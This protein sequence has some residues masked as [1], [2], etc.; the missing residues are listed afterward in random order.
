MYS[1]F[2]SL[3]LLFAVT[4]GGFTSAPPF[5]S[6]KI[7]HG[8]SSKVAREDG[9]IPGNVAVRRASNGNIVIIVDRSSNSAKTSPDGIPDIVFRFAPLTEDLSRHGDISFNLKQ[10]QV[11]LQPGR[12]A[13]FTKNNR[14]AVSLSVEEIEKTDA[15]FPMFNDQSRDLPNAVRLHQGIGLVRQAPIISE[16]SKS[17]NAGKTPKAAGLPAL[18][19]V[20]TDFVIRRDARA[21]DD[22]GFEIE[23]CTAGGQ[24][25]TSCSINCPS[26]NGCAVTCG[27]GYWACCKCPNNCQCAQKV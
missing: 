6:S 2:I 25:A 24:G 11:F 13:V 22:G 18:I 17:A 3:L 21:S 15:N 4:Q 8:N 14:L 26:G 23:G 20:E 12:L 27:I 10:A 9:V 7:F 19:D 5:N 16:S 1:T